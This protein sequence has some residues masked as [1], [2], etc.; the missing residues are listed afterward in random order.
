MKNKKGFVM[1]VTV[2]LITIFTFVYISIIPLMGTYD[3]LAYRN[4]DID[5]VY[6]LYNIRKM[7]N[8]DSHK[9][10]I[11]LQ[12]FLPITCSNLDDESYCNE[13][14]AYLELRTDVADNYI[15]IFTTSIYDN[16]NSFRDYEY[17]TDHEMYKYLS[18]HTDFDGRVLVLLDTKNHTT[19]YLKVN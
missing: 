6:R 1:T 2:F 8:K 9:S 17:D 16:L 7:I 19:A 10:N 18:K 13:L 15:L 4:S 11:I 5:I 14:M 3:D 12:D